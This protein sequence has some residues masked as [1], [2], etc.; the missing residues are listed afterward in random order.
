MKRSQLKIR[1]SSNFE[2]LTGLLEW[3]GGVGAVARA[4]RLTTYGVYKWGDRSIPEHHFEAVIKAAKSAGNLLTMEQLEAFNARAKAA[5]GGELAQA[6]TSAAKLRRKQLRAEAEAARW[7]AKAKRYKR[8]AD[9][10]EKRI[11]AHRKGMAD[12]LARDEAASA[13]QG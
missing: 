10:I 7:S 5:R 12:E 3:C 11:G 13:A 4:T 9:G 6:Q 2:S 1:D 8:L